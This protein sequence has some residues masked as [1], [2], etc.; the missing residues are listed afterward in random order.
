M[1]KAMEGLPS[2]QGGIGS[3]AS[4]AKINNLAYKAYY[5]DTGL[6]LWTDKPPK[7]Q[8]LAWVL[9]EIRKDEEAAKNRKGHTL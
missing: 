4:R 2:G 8:N 9:D 5:K 6:D 1:V 3:N 7:G